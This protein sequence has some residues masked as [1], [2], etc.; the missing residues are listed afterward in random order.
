MYPS[1]P[2]LDRTGL[3]GDSIACR[4]SSVIS[5]AILTAYETNVINIITPVSL[6]NVLF[7]WLCVASANLYQGQNFN[8]KW[9]G[10]R[11]RTSGLIQIW[12]GYLL[13]R[14]SRFCNLH[15]LYLYLAVVLLVFK[16]YF[17]TEFCCVMLC[18]S[19]IYAMVSSWVSVTFMYS[20]ETSKHI[21]KR[22]TP[23]G[24]HTILVFPHQKLW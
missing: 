21:V 6:I 22:F 5:C 11:I 9:S 12:I 7:N 20:I 1:G 8:Q 23:S 13:D 16:L 24:S 19:V 3:V 18:I 15:S 10:I 17:N 4:P 14:S 2:K